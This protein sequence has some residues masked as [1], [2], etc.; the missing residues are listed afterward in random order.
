LFYTIHVNDPLSAG[1]GDKI[2]EIG[3]RDGLILGQV[4][5]S[6]DCIKRKSMYVPVMFMRVVQG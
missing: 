6:I 5:G 4:A 1:E 2:L 3:A